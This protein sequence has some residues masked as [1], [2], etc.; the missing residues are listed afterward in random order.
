MA[1]QVFRQPSAVLDTLMLELG[2]VGWDGVTGDLRIG[3]GTIGG[4]PAAS[5]F[6]SG[7]S[8]VN[9]FSGAVTLDLS[10]L[11]D[12]SANTPAA[13]W[14][15]AWDGAQWLPQ[16]QTL[17]LGSVGD[18]TDVD[19]TTVFP[20]V[21]EFL[22]WDGSNWVPAI[23]SGGALVLTDLTDTPSSY[24]GQSMKVLR[25]NSPETATEFIDS[26]ALLLGSIDQLSDVDTVTFPPSG[27]QLLAW[28]GAKWAPTSLPTPTFQFKGLTDTPSNYTG[29]GLKMLR[30]D[31]L[32]SQVEF[33]TVADVAL[34]S[35][36]KHSD[37][38]TTSVAPT[39]NQVLS[40][41]G[42]N[43]VPTTVAGGVTAIDD[44][45]DVD[46]TTVTPTTN[47][48]LSWNGTNWVP[49]T[50]AAGGGSTPYNQSFVI[51]NW[52]VS[53]TDLIITVTGA[54]HGKADPSNIY[55]LEDT[56]TNFLDAEIAFDI[57]QSNQ[58]VVLSIANVSGNAFDGEVFIG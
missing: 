49:A 6:S 37:V 46:T 2:S 53:G 4:I 23:G 30:V 24:L 45:S 1:Q 7:V 13:G 16:V 43:W 39:N 19:T 38:D 34:G 28:N 58:D 27:G 51:A 32:E 10:D 29:D 50:V 41:N 20:L 40:W 15:I 56:G 55:V 22:S 36:D 31:S 3:D 12:V 57:N 48:V 8:T 21:G 25:V 42:V 54:T 33:V 52:S 47:Q 14:V 11:L 9:G 17:T 44:L 26:T 5:T 35:V 18:H